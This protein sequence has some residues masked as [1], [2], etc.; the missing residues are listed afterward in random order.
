M[1]VV[2]G[3]ILFLRL[4][5]F[6]ALLLGALVVATLTPAAALQDFALQNGA[7]TEAAAQLASQSAG[8]RIAQGFGKTTGQVGIVIAMASIIGICL[9][10]SGAADRMV[11]SALRFL[12]AERAPLA[13]VG[14]GF[15]LAIPVFFDTVFYL[16]IPLAKATRLRTGKS[17]LFYVLGIVAGGTMAHS[18]VPPTPGPLFVAGEFGVDIGL[19][20]LVGLAVGIVASTNGFLFAWWM[21]RRI[22]LP[23]R[24]SREAL[25]ELEAIA[26]KQ[27]NQLPPL[28]LSVVPILLPVILIAGRT[29]FESVGS[30]ELGF[31]MA[32]GEKNI[33][34]TVSAAIALVMLLWKT[35]AGRVVQAS[36][37]ALRTAGVIIL[38]IGAGGAFGSALQ[39]TGIGASIQ[40][41]ATT[42][43]VGILPLAFFLTA[44]IRTAQGS[45]TVA[46]VTS[47]GALI[48]LADPGQLGFH[49]VYLAVA[50]GCGSKPIWWMNDSGF[51]VVS[52]MSG[53]TEKE[54]LMALTPLAAIMGVTGLIATM[55][56]AHFLPL[57]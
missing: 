51:W 33:A 40:T 34:L 8:E 56:L 42:Y 30:V 37:K 7:S 15:A 9:L 53:M 41:I 44:L 49:P 21:N 3:G 16:M 11:R 20:I 35:E 19:M 36:R 25:E 27:D 6:L 46:M 22:D 31:L 29:L 28:W 47:A 24:E 13:F 18:L 26:A 52:Q 5:A 32:L 1:L 2:I 10:E 39:Q 12:G 45:A 4:H 43:Q 54:G 57:V 14:T 17:Y 23:L 50:I 55:L 38:I 48:A